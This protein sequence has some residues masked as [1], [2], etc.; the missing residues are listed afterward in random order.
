MAKLSKNKYPYWATLGGSL[1][2][3]TGFLMSC[4]LRVVNQKKLSS[5][6]VIEQYFLP[7]VP[8]LPFDEGQKP[9]NDTV[10]KIRNTMVCVNEGEDPYVIDIEV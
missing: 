10:I 2:I 1:L 6:D 5:D 3:L 4:V 7:T 8:D 9:S